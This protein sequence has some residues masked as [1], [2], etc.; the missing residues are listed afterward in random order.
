VSDFLNDQNIKGKKSSYYYLE[1][2]VILFI[3]L[4]IWGGGKPI[5]GVY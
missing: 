5:I 3:Y 1:K 2:I 4:F